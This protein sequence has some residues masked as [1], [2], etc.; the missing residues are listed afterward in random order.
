[1]MKKLA[2][3][4]LVICCIMLT[5]GLSACGDKNKYIP[6]GE[7]YVKTSPAC[8]DA[9]VLEVI[10]IE[11]EYKT[12]QGEGDITVP[13]TVGF[14]HQPKS[15]GLCDGTFYIL[16][17]VFEHPLKDNLQPIWE[18][19]VEYSDSF[20]DEK[21]NSTV[22]KDR[23]FLVIPLYGDFYPLYKERAEI[24][25]PE[26]VP[27][28]LVRVECV[29]LGN[30]FEM[31]VELEFSFARIDDILTLDSEAVYFNLAE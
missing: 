21:Y 23:S 10:D 26:G 12:Y 22:P 2:M 9:G 15:V 3:I 30:G 31:V 17:Q 8:G 13:V 29:V 5:M 11:A 28:G 18:K 7:F 24:V 6:K 25:F 27:S 16:Y 20:Y 14:G 19:K 4:T 1:M